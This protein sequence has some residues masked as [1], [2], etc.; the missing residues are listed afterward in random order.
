M[1][2]TKYHGLG[3]DYLVMRPTD[4]DVEPDIRQVRRICD[5]NFGIG[6]DGILPRVS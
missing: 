4:L 2:Y 6:S 3:N 5:R 1:R